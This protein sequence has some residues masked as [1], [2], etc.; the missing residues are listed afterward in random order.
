[1]LVHIL[2]LARRKGWS[3]NLVGVDA[4]P[5]IIAF[6][7]RNIAAYPAVRLETFDIFSEDF[8]NQE[9]DIAIGTL[10]FHHF[11]SAVLTDFLASS[12]GKP[13]SELSSTTSTGTHWPTIPSAFSQGGFPGRLW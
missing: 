3:A 13:A 8:K 11:P 10:F 4:N 1:M 6:A 2:R 5:H 7:R 9:M 12:S